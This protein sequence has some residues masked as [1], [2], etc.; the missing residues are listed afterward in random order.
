MRFALV[1][2]ALM[3]GLGAGLVSPAHAQS[4]RFRGLWEG[5]FHGGRGEQPMAL[6]IRPRGPS[7]FAG[8]WYQEGQ[9]LAE[10]DAARVA[11]DSLIFSLM[12]FDIV[13]L[14]SG[15][16]L[17]VDFTVRNGRT[18]HFDMTRTTSD[19]TR[20]PERPDRPEP[21][22]PRIV[23]EPPPDSVYA[24]HALA[25]GTRA[26]LAPC[27]ER[28]TLFLVGGGATQADLDRRFVELAGGKAA[29]IVV[30][31][32]P[33]ID[34]GDPAS[35]DR[36]AGALHGLVGQD[37]VSVLHTTS[38]KV[39]DSEAFVAPL[40]QATG[41]WITG[42]EASWFLDSYLGT[43][44]ERE[45][46]A[47]LERGGV[48]GGTSAGAVIWASQMMTFREDSAHRELQPMRVENLVFGDHHGN[49]IGLLRS[50]TLAPHLSSFHLESSLRKMLANRPGLLGIGIDEATALE[51]HAGVGHVRGRGIVT[52][53]SGEGDTTR[54]VLR[55]GARYD[56]TRR[57]T[58]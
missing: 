31:P 36:F 47:V 42:G 22:G 14:A 51:L 52:V 2:L 48:V 3:A 57:R 9:V 30:I 6:V 54:A 21:A 53:Q 25:P 45:L 5:M 12:S 32:T 8:T 41:V 58:L 33:S 44:T 40:R 26:G 20:V 10:T 34:D 35:P 28:G 23:R 43:R 50:I 49:G 15:D 16:H 55:E 38:R 46:T 4:D 13:A 1:A 27:L 11:G 56:F 17:A 7:S 39:A 19:T 29:R 37:R 18:H 24:A